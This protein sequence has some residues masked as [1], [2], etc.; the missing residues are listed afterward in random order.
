MKYRTEKRIIDDNGEVYDVGDE[1][2]V[3]YNK[4]SGYEGVDSAVR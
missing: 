3:I 1:V 4:E 2:S